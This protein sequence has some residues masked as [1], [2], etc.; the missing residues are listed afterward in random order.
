MWFTVHNNVVHYAI[1]CIHELNLSIETQSV[2]HSVC[3]TIECHYEQKILYQH[4]PDY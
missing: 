4:K 2:P 3:Q 1:F